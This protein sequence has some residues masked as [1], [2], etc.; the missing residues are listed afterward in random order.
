MDAEVAVLADDEVLVLLRLA[1][2]QARLAVVA[3]PA[4]PHEVPHQVGAVDAARRVH[5]VAAA[6]AAVG[7]DIEPLELFY[8][9]H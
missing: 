5:R 1:A 7:K 8:S 6:E 4:V 3:R 9:M 2:H